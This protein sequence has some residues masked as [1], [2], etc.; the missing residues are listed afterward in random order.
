MQPI[1]SPTAPAIDRLYR[2]TRRDDWGVAVFLW[3]R[4]GKRCYRF[5]DGELRTFAQ[6]FWNLLVPTQAPADGSAA[7]APR[8]A[9]PLRGGG[10]KK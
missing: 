10:S 7:A 5:A 1:G 3:E 8:W 6:A 4:D 9:P 2:H